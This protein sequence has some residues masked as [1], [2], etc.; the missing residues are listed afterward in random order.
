MH[1]ASAPVF[2]RTLK[3]MLAFIEKAE[4][5]A[6]TRK[7]DPEVLLQQRLA[8]D[9]APLVRQFQFASD[10]SKL[11]VA[12]LA[13]QTAPSFPDTETT[14]A[15]IKERLKKTIEYIESVPASAIDGSEEREVV[16]KFPSGE[17]NF[18]GLGYLTGFALPNFFFHATT[19]YAIL[20]HNGV[21][22]G[23]R[24]FLGGA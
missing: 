19:A 12:R 23:K 22:L 1:K 18:K 10:A 24:D 20:R 5:N 7:F 2:V 14:F 15:E 8:P 17:M 3:N 13:G 9:M 21:D 4:A 11:A 6:A 16:L